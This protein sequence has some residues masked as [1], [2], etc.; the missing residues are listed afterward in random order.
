MGAISAGAVQ[1]HTAPIVFEGNTTFIHNIAHESGGEQ[2]PTPLTA[3]HDDYPNS[4][5]TINSVYL[6]LMAP[7][8]LVHT[9]FRR[10]HEWPF[11]K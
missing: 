7:E 4:T 6:A 2:A 11:D 3:L 9:G 1:A 8:F 10:G 5:R